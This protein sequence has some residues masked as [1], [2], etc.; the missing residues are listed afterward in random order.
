MTK[1]ELED[2]KNEVID[3]IKQQYPQIKSENTTIS[4]IL[5]EYQ[6]QA[7]NGDPGSLISF[8]R[9][10]GVRISFTLMNLVVSYNGGDYTDLVAD[11]VKFDLKN[12]RQNQISLTVAER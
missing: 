1:Q 6:A 3:F 10:K 2:I 7:A 5:S 11:N 8:M 9:R 12:P 4:Q